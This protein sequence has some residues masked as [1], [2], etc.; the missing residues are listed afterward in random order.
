MQGHEGVPPTQ[1]ARH[2]CGWKAL[3]DAQNSDGTAAFLMKNQFGQ[4]VTG[5]G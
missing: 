5:D 3:T 2:A 4:T 1:A